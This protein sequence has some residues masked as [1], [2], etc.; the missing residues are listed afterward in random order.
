MQNGDTEFLPTS[1]KD[2]LAFSVSLD[3]H[4]DFCFSLFNINYVSAICSEVFRY[5]L[6]IDR[7]IFYTTD[8]EIEHEIGGNNRPCQ[9]QW[10]NID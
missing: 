8:N 6:P 10:E 3:F 7:N 5:G 4:C 9:T 1:C 2:C